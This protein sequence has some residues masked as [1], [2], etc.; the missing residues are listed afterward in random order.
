MMGMTPGAPAGPRER[1]VR[2]QGVKPINHQNLQW[3]GRAI[4]AKTELLLHRRKDRRAVGIGVCG[5]GRRP[6]QVEIPLAAQ[7]GTVDNDPSCLSSQRKRTNPLIGNE[8]AVSSVLVPRIPHTA[9]S[10]GGGVAPGL[11]AASARFAQ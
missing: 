8:P 9:P 10:C 6:F 5:V 4:Q 3:S 7:T 11:P 1:L 2:N